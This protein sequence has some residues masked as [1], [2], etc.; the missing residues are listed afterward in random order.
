MTHPM[1]AGFEEAHA[2]GAVA[3]RDA[4][5][6]AAARAAG[7]H[8]ALFDQFLRERGHSQAPKLAPTPLALA[9]EAERQAAKAD[10]RVKREA[11]RARQALPV[12]ENTLKKA[13]STENRTAA[14]EALSS[15]D[16]FSA[17]EALA[18]DEQREYNPE[19]T[20]LA[21]HNDDSLVRCVLGPVGS[22]KSSL[23]VMEIFMR[24]LRVPAL[25][26]IRRSR[27]LIVRSTFAELK[28]TTIETFRFWLGHLGKFKFDSPIVFEA[29]QL[30]PDGT[31]MHLDVFFM[32]LDRPDD[33]SKLRSLEITGAWINEGSLITTNFIPEIV[34]RLRFMGNMYGSSVQP[35]RG[36]IVDSNFPTVRHWIYTQFESKRPDGYKLFKQPPALV[37]DMEGAYHANP[38]AEN[39]K[40]LPDGFEYY[41]RMI[42]SMTL[43]KVKVLVLAQ[44]G[45]S[46]DGKPVYDGM[47]DGRRH[48]A[49]EPLRF[50]RSRHLIIGMDWGLNP[51]AVFLQMTPTG[52][53]RVLMELCPNDIT[54]EQFLAELVLPTLAE[55][56]SN[57][58]V[59]VVGDPSGANRNAQGRLTAFQHVLA[60]GLPVIGAPT[61]DFLARRDAVGFFLNRG[62]DGFLLDPGCVM[63]HEGFNGGYRLGRRR[64]GDG[65]SDVPE[66][67]LYTH[68]HDALQYGALYFNRT[69]YARRPAQ[70]TEVREKKRGFYY[71]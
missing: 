9:R 37:L 56:F 17:S 19:A 39:I 25:R 32:P 54:L 23:C 27:W 28:T 18:E 58:R 16:V 36:I 38:D 44:Y 70:A 2:R 8:G 71:G 34:T 62:A 55:R 68:P 6:E 41:F 33:V 42:S 45:A 51:A 60:A 65:Y 30:L 52:G 10:R 67:T 50:D 13:R 29:K 40:N 49:Q 20:A 61:N 26:G 22:G 69:R 57:A 48:L 4:A 7:L 11:E 24:A 5:I 64:T 31:T 3:A 15:D 47:W 35:W 63:L 1:L 43:D 46:Y 21:F 59:Q 14:E 12:D 66:E 53:L